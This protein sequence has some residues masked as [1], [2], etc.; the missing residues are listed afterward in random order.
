LR[1]FNLVK[2]FGEIAL[3]DGKEKPLTPVRATDGRSRISFRVPG[4]ELL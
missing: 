2:V 3:L 1:S 4:A